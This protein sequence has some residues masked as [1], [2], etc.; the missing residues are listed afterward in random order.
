MINSKS[1]PIL[2]PNLPCRKEIPDHDFRNIL[3]NELLKKYEQFTLG[4][5][6]EKNPN[7]FSHC[8]TPDCSFAFFRGPDDPIQFRCPV[9]K[10][11][12]C[13]EYKS[14]FHNGQTCEDFQKKSIAHF[15]SFTFTS[16][17][18]SV[19]SNK[20]KIFGRSNV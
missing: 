19:T 17:R 10:K 8:L 6:L 7:D 5:A 14:P 4:L 15:L 9:C 13:L 16:Q 12:Y 1:F 3:S 11:S 18:K 2:C 20:T